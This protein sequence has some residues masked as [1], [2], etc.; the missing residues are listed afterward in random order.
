MNVKSSGLVYCLHLQNHTNEPGVKEKQQLGIET[1]HQWEILNI[2][3][4]ALFNSI[5]NQ[6]WIL[7]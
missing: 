4:I 3:G 5:Q 7:T 2:K 1:G 6:P